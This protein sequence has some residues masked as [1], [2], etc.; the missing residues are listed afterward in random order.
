MSGGIERTRNFY[1]YFKFGQVSYGFKRIIQII[2]TNLIL[3]EKRVTDIGRF[4]TIT[5]IFRDHW[6]QGKRARNKLETWHREII[7][8]KSARVVAR[9]NSRQ[10]PRERTEDFLV[11]W[12]LKLYPFFWYTQ[13]TPRF[14]PK[15]IIFIIFSFLI[16]IHSLGFLIIYFLFSSL[17]LLLVLEFV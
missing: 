12:N 4:R 16:F 8:Q 14:H 17:L 7:K 5:R 11:P 10:K 6:K 1:I 2:M 9:L 15:L 13:P 3:I